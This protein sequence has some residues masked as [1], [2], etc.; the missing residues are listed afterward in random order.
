MKYTRSIPGFLI[1]TLIAGSF[2]IAS[3][4]IASDKADEGHA[5][6]KIT[7]VEKVPFGDATAG[8]Q[9][10]ATCAACHGVDGNST[11][12]EWPSLA[13]QHPEYLYEQL[14]MI[15]DGSRSAPLM[16]GQLNTTNDQDLKDI[17]AYFAS[18]D[19]KSGEVDADLFEHG[20]SIFR[21]GNTESGLPSCASC[22]G[23]TGAGNPMS[24]YPSLIGQQP[25]YVLKSLNDYAS[26]ARNANAQ[27]KIMKE[28]ASLMT[29]AEKEAVASYL[30]GL[31]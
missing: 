11:N 15:K 19:G 18:L 31:Q 29:D 20:Q 24:K 6:E 2:A 12:A 30:R 26:G 21:G 13:G 28:V 23:A 9:K 16:V 8:K 10:V 7:H 1:S 22:H 3:T 14:V 4:A 17:A 25:A 5:E 27:Q